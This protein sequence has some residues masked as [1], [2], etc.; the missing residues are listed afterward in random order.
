MVVTT[1]IMISDRSLLTG[2][3]APRDSDP[4]DVLTQDRGPDLHHGGQR[5][6]PG[7]QGGHVAGDHRVGGVPGL[8]QSFNYVS[9]NGLC[10]ILL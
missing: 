4:C 2:V 7:G 1:L 3:N 8:G 6:E 10:L 5:G 9:L